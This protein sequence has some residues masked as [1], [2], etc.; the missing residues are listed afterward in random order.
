MAPLTSFALIAPL[1]MATEPLRIWY[2][3]PLIVSVSL[4]YAATRNENMGTIVAHAA[5]FGGWL[6]VF[7]ASMAALLTGLN[8]IQ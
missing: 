8:W 2:A 4:V 5:R 7:I 1:L 6:V 3:L